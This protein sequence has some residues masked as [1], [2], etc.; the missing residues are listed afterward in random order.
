M[1]TTSI[2]LRLYPNQDQARSFARFQGS[3]RALWNT[4]LAATNEAKEKNGRFL[5]WGELQAVAVAWKKDPEAPWRLELPAHAVLQVSNNMHAAFKNYYERR[6]RRPRFRSRSGRQIRIYCV[7]QNTRF[8][9]NKAMIPK[10]GWMRWRGAAI[11]D[12]RLVCG[13]VWRDAGDRWMFHGVFEVESDND[14][15]E[16]EADIIAVDLGLKRFATTTVD[17]EKFEHIEPPRFMKKSLKRLRRAQRRLVRRCP[18]S[19][20]RERAKRSVAQ[21]WRKARNQRAD[22]QHKVS[23]TFVNSAEVIKLDVVNV[24]GMFNLKYMGL[25]AGDVALGLFRKKLE[26]KAARAGRRL[27]YADRWYASSQTCSACGEIDPAMKNLRRRTFR[28][29]CGHKMDRDEN[30]AVNLFRYGEERRNQLSSE[31]TRVETGVRALGSGPI[32]ETRMS[33]AASAAETF[34]CVPVESVRSSV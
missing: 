4:L 15:P 32:E 2:Q 26:Y 21:I 14:A 9:G 20:R 31:V 22:F 16:P 10:V 29:S 19:K 34:P 11:P 17:G 3:L 1:H 28:C 30:A 12:G 23:R 27:E 13:Q 24:K 5:K 6:C 8:Q 7:N 25:T 33:E 18:G